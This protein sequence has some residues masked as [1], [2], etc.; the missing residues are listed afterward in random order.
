MR[1]PIVPM[2]MWIAVTLGSGIW[3]FNILRKRHPQ[4]KFARYAWLL[5]VA[6]VTALAVVMMSTP[7]RTGD[8]AALLKV[9]W[10]LFVVITFTFPQIVYLLFD[11]IGRLPRLFG[12]K[13]CKWSSRTGIAAAY[14]LFAAM[15][16]GALFNRFNIDVN[17]VTVEIDGLPASFDG[18]RIVQFSDL[19]TGSYGD[20]TSF[21]E[22]I[23]D[24][25]NAQNP[26]AV[27]FTGDIVNRR[28][29]ELTPFAPYLNKIKV[30]DGVVSILGNHDYGDYFRWFNTDARM[31][32]MEELTDLYREMGWRLLRNHKIWLTNGND[33]IA[34][35]GVENI[36]DKPFPVYGSLARTYPDIGDEKTKI[37]LS[38][39]PSHWTDSISDRD[40]INIALTL[41]GHTHAMQAE[42]AGISPAALR[43][44]KWGGLYKDKSGQHQ[45]YV[46][47]GVGTVGF[48]MRLGATPEISV[49]TLRP[50]GAGNE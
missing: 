2:I 15:W 14:A 42:I 32:N 18:Y 24:A 28:S 13:R 37:L 22:K 49:I 38:H 25:I 6:A 31:S 48:P 4:M 20:D 33:S 9:N 16:W 10:M 35:L 40:D 36:G 50:K 41:S 26:D 11:L 7:H 21:V 30:K 44:P 45:L 8:D 12:K 3:I 46:N 34:V 27:F 1:L 47:I 39:N 19:H 5:L 29:R 17:E 23:V 43:Y